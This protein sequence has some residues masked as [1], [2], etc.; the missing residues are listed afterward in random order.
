MKPI[1]KKGLR[2]DPSDYRPT[3][4][5]PLISKIFEKIVHDQMIDY[6]YQYNILHKYQSGFRTK[7]LTDFC[8]SYMNDKFWKALI[9]SA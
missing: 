5:L 2:M 7:H 4:L 1:F 9:I 8:L 3:S 6:L